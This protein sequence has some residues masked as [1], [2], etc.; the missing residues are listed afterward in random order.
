MSHVAKEDVSLLE[1]DGDAASSDRFKLVVDITNT[2]V[3]IDVLH[4][5]SNYSY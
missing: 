5:V 1:V 3:D 2:T 4:K